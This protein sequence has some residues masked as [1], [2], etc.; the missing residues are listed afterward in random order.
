MHVQAGSKQLAEAVAVNIQARRSPETVPDQATLYY[1]LS[2]TAGTKQDH[3]TLGSPVEIS[4]LLT[5]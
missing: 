1:G 3:A 2:K 5:S 4:V